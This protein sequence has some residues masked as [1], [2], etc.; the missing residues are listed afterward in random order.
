M[1]R[2][3]LL[4]VIQS[5]PLWCSRRPAATCVTTHQAETAP[6]LD[7][8]W[9]FR[10][11]RKQWPATL[12]RPLDSAAHYRLNAARLS[13]SPNLAFDEFW[14]RQRYPEI[15]SLVRSGAFPSGWEHY[16][17]CGCFENRNPVWW[18]DEDW[19][20]TKNPDVQEAIKSTQF[21]CGFEH[22]LLYGIRQ[23]L[24]PSLYFDV[25]WYR[26]HYLSE[27]PDAFPLPD[28]LLST[29]RAERC[30]VQFFD[31][32]WYRTTYLSQNGSPNGSVNPCHTPYEHYIYS[33]QCLQYSP[34]PK[35]HERAYRELNPD[36]AGKISTGCYLSGFEHYVHEGAAAG[37]SVATHLGTAGVDY[38]GPA[39]LPVY[40]KILKLHLRQLRTLKTLAENG[41]YNTQD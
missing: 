7:W 13:L 40:E 38:A 15:D 26:H 20:R 34:S 16:L 23:D 29:D 3:R 19:Y 2:A 5:T 9:Y 21:V 33:G 6:G 25:K 10:T 4:A 35:F 11:Y 36:A 37:C 39:F 27:T 12:R 8:T 32:D 28:Y 31:S 17:E 41:S 18:F 24:S 14:Y 30:P 22:Y 1:T